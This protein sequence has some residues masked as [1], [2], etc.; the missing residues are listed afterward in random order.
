MNYRNFLDS[1]QGTGPLDFYDV[2]ALS[3]TRSFAALENKRQE[4]ILDWKLSEIKETIRPKVSLS[5]R[6][7]HS[8]LDDSLSLEKSFDMFLTVNWNIFSIQDY[9]TQKKYYRELTRLSR[10]KQK[11]FM[12]QN[13]LEAVRLYFLYCRSKME[14]KLAAI[15]YK[16]AMDEFEDT[17]VLFK[18][19]RLSD[20]DLRT[21]EDKL[22]NTLKERKLKELEL[23][24]HRKSL[25]SFIF[26]DETISV[27]G[28]NYKIGIPPM[29]EE[30]EL[31]ERAVLHSQDVLDSFSQAQ[32]NRRLKKSLAYKRW[33]DF[34]S[35]LYFSNSLSVDDW[36]WERDKGQTFVGL[37]LWWNIPLFCGDEW[38]RQA[39]KAEMDYAN[40]AYQHQMLIQKTSRHVQRLVLSIKENEVERTHLRELRKISARD[41]LLSHSDFKKGNLSGRQF[42]KYK[43]RV[44][45][46]SLKTKIKELERILL[47]A[48]LH[49]L[50]GEDLAWLT[51]EVS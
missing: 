2:V 6:F 38:S 5:S 41:L 21:Q 4:K 36:D 14:T 16:T 48:E 46:L 43:N 11:W 45:Q 25:L 32:N 15:E 19:K 24:N 22:K 49:C 40:M 33:T 30:K 47:H 35:S 27:S 31:I 37:G 8:N 12:K 50:C 18:M 39:A 44:K 29:P 9:F 13:T 20:F 28:F 10:E 7:Q 26:L 34:S 23:E 1:Y 17:E 42:E 3:Q 51:E